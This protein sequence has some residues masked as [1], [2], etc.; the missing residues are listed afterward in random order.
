MQCLFCFSPLIS[1]FSL[2]I[3]SASSILSI[4]CG[5]KKIAWAHVD[6]RMTVL[7][8]QQQDCPNFLRGTYMASAYLRDVSIFFFCVFG[9]L[10]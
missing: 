7:D 10:N 2:L 3:Q 4:I 6:R 1:T 9:Y 5:V 8:W